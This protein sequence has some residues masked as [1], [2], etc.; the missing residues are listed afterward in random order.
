MLKVVDVE[1]WMFKLNNNISKEILSELT[2]WKLDTKF[3]ELWKEYEVTTEDDLKHTREV[4]DKHQIE[5]EDAKTYM[6]ARFYLDLDDFNSYG[7]KVDMSGE[8]LMEELAEEDYYYDY[9][10]HYYQVLKNRANA[11][12]YGTAKF[13]DEEV[14]KAKLDKE[15]EKLD[16]VTL[17]MNSVIVRAPQL[18]CQE[19]HT[20]ID[21]A[22]R[23]LVID[24]GEVSE[25]L[26]PIKHCLD[27]DVFFMLDVNFKE[28]KKC[29]NIMCNVISYKEY[30]TKGIVKRI[31]DQLEPK[32]KLK[33]MGYSVSRQDGL[34]EDKRAKIL[35]GAI[36]F[37]IMT[38]DEIVSFLRWCY[39]QHA[40]AHPEAAQ[41]YLD[42]ISYLEYLDIEEKPI[43][44]IDEFIIE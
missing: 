5:Y 38:K 42:D 1:C 40:T 13:I 21:I 12:L 44:D 14:E 10:E 37:G 2:G 19:E 22:G 39:R 20:V 9:N 6:Y 29:G 35:R 36:E 4:L 23:V 8:F 11:E 32:S 30:E 17:S 3:N 31:Y 7:E 33:L 25:V 34:S 24:D 41:K 16:R 15:L 43:V 27:E 18:K 26:V 28:L